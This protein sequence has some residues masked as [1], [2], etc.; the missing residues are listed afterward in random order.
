LLPLLLLLLHGCGDLPRDPE[1]TLARIREKRTMRVGVCEAAPWLVR[2][3]DDEPR[4]IEADLVRELGRQEGAR[5]EWVWGNVEHHYEDLEKRELDLVAGGLTDRSP[6]LKKVG[7]T[8]PFV[9]AEGK[10]HV[11]AV[12]P[13]ENAWLVRV[14]SHLASQ[15]ES[16]ERAVPG[17]RTP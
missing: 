6:W 12:P 17:A 14:E 7:A 10:K 11:M 3:G 16:I 4:G 1:E 15:A 2:G 5:I 9:E 13:G 8:R